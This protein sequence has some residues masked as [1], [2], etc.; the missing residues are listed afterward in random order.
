[1]IYFIYILVSLILFSCTNARE[2]EDGVN[3]FY[4][5]SE[6]L[7][8]M[9]SVSP[10]EFDSAAFYFKDF[11]FLSL[12]G[13][14]QLALDEITYPYLSIEENKLTGEMI[15]FSYWS[16]SVISKRIF[17][18][19]GKFYKEE[20]VVDEGGPLNKIT[21]YYLGD[22]VIT[23]NNRIVPYDSSQSYL[24][25]FSV[26]KWNDSLD[27][28]QGFKKIE[29]IYGIREFNIKP[30]PNYNNVPLTGKNLDIIE[31]DVNRVNDLI[32][33]STRR[34][35]ITPLPKKAVWERKNCFNIQGFSYYWWVTFGWYMK[36]QCGNLGN[37][38]E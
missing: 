16:H 4:H 31:T 29:Y 7:D 23:Y 37:V 25:S 26:Q 18:K 6:K 32:F 27:Q 17:K 34:E 33:E 12:K 30:G 8:K 9:D 14:K 20:I 3:Y 38:S 5:N 35:R 19:E 15:V 22:K 36:V 21:S 28:S 11:D 2:K 1:M 24:I 13:K 10:N